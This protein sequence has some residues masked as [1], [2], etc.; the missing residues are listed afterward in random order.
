MYG[1]MK[2][3][4]MQHSDF[5]KLGLNHNLFMEFLSRRYRKS[6]YEKWKELPLIKAVSDGFIFSE[7]TPKGALREIFVEEIYN[8]KGFTPHKNQ[9][10]IDVGAN[11]GDS[12]IWW[13]KKFWAR[14]I[15]FEPLDDVFKI[16]EEN[17]TL[18]KADVKAYN[19]A[20]GNGL[21]ISGNSEGTM[22]IKGGNVKFRT[23]KLDSYALEQVDILKIDVEG[24][25]FEVIQ[26]AEKTIRR[27]KPRIIL[28]THSKELRRKCNGFLNE[29]GY[30]LKFEGR[31]VISHSPGMDKVTNLFYSV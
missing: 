20:L 18:N 21:D 3:K 23:E 24:F 4:L 30:K 2:W 19:M 16:L 26:G 29:L 6:T 28:E 10:V 31:T 14:V 8:V 7:R 9:T 22:L 27:L 1:S 25:E 11:Y 17:I 13:S 5:A 12:A 15:A